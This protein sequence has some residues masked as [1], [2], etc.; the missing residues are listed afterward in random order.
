MFCLITFCYGFPFHIPI[1]SAPL[2][3]YFGELLK[4][5]EITV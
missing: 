4:P 5:A 2:F 3:F 1:P